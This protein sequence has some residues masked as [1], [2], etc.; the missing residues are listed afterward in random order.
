MTC[1]VL[2]DSVDE[3]QW[4]KFA[5]DFADYSIYQT[6]AYQQVRSQTDKQVLSRAVVIDDTGSVLTMCQIR[7]KQVK[8]LGFRIGYIQAGPLLQ[9]KGGK[10]RCSSE[11]LKALQNAYLGKAVNILRIVPNLFNNGTAHD[12]SEMIQSADFEP[13][14]MVDPYRTFVLPV[15]NSEDEMLMS[16]HKSFRRDLRKAQQSG[17]ESRQGC[18][19][20]FFD[21]LSRL[22]A[23]SKERKGFRGVDGEIFAK[24]QALLPPEEKMNIVLVYDKGE[25][26]SAHLASNLGETGLVLLAAS[27]EKG[28][29]CGSSYLVWWQAAL[30]ARKAGMKWYDLGGIDR[31]KNPHVYQFKSRMGGS[32]TEHI[33]AFEVSTGKLC[34]TLWRG[35]EK[36]YR[37]V[38]S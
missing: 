7:I 1:K 16:L 28:L 34:K 21:V 5:I 17:L 35:C 32:E 24:T 18:D 37:L 25:I 6:W 3:S 19:E 31:A 2:I 36:A 33:G 12:F 20:D 11:A 10:I 26:V 13:V 30:A 4:R 27:N 9:D 29:A 22:Y 15:S 8:A 38:R 14:K 23:I